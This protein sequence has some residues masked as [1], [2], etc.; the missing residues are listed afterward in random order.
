MD[1]GSLLGQREKKPGG[2]LLRGNEKGLASFS[3]QKLRRG[4]TAFYK[5]ISCNEQLLEK[6]IV[7]TR[8]NVYKLQ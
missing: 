5:Y 4:M 7:G 2:W 3:L 1:R 8:T 6:D